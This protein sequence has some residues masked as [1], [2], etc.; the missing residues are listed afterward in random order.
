MS[1]LDEYFEDKEKGGL[2]HAVSE[3][4]ST[5]LNTEKHVED[6]FTAAHTHVI[7]AM[8][9]HDPEAIE[10]AEKVVNEVMERFEDKK[11]G[12][13]FIKADKDWNIIDRNKSFSEVEAIFGMLMHLYEINKKDEYLLKALDYLDLTL[14]RA[15]DQRDG[16]FF[17]LYREDWSRA[18]DK[19]DLATQAGM[20]QHMGGGWK[21]GMDSPYA[22]RAEAFK[23]RA[24]AFVNLILEKAADKVN[25]GFYTTFAA[26]WKPLEKEKEV[27]QL[28]SLALTLYFTYHNFGPSIWGPRKGSHAY[29]GRP[30]PA[31][32]AYRGPAPNTDPVSPKAYPYGR[33]VV[34]IADILCEKAWDGEHGGFYAKLTEKYA[35]ADKRKIMSAQVASL[36]ALNVAYRLTGFPRFRAKLIDAVKVVEDKCFDQE[37]GGVYTEF[38]QDW[39]PLSRDKVCGPNLTLGGL[40]SMFGPVIDG[41]PVMRNTLKIWADPPAQTIKRGQSAQVTVTVQNQ[42]FEPVKV[43]VGGLSAPTRWMDPPEMRVDLAPHQVTSYKLT[44]TPPQGVPSGPYYFELTLAPAGEV[45]EYVSVGGKVVLE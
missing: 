28:G 31:V 40:L 17:S 37:H 38:A 26:D 33:T 19:K 2:F 6:Q 7:G 10:D 34:E 23:R 42:N 20:L 32:Y 22:V 29:T 35:P 9:S 3:D 8:I 30:Y 5:V 1:F 11:H 27:A 4:F 41:V 39:T 44:I 18:V 13:F 16:G 12:G 36:M 45:G 21:D 14:E 25:G 15:W 43:R 24:E